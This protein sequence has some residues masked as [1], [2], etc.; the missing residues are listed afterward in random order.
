MVPD[1]DVP[2]R[3]KGGERQSWIGQ[4]GFLCRCWDRQSRW[5][6]CLQSTSC[7]A[8]RADNLF[9]QSAHG[10]SGIPGLAMWRGGVE[11]AVRSGDGD[12]VGVV[13]VFGAGSWSGAK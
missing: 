9:W 10:R 6:A 2:C 11:F 5:S 1:G 8:E 7:T 3:T 12:D 4:H 13:A